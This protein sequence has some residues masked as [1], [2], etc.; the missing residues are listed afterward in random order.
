MKNH[1]LS[2]MELLRKATST[3]HML[4]PLRRIASNLPLPFLLRSLTSLGP[5]FLWLLTG[6]SQLEMQGKFLGKENRI[7]VFYLAPSLSCFLRQ[8]A[9]LDKAL[10]LLGMMVHAFNSR[11][12]E[13]EGGRSL[14]DID[15]PGL[16]SK[17]QASQGYI[18]RP[19]LKK[20]IITVKDYLPEGPPS[21]PWYLFCFCQHHVPD[22]SLFFFFCKDS[23]LFLLINVS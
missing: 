13:T 23:F 19:G 16:C 7:N 12:L 9:M 17:F 14:P 15:H 18:V 8:P 4:P 20:K 3:A 11:T 10:L 5:H 22:H 1:R 6:F 2:S 21:L